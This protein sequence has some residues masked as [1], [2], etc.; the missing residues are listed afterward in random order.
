[1]NGSALKWKGKK[2][3]CNAPWFSY[4]QINIVVL[5]AKNLNDLQEMLGKL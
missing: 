1:M 4:L 2:G 5:L 3:C